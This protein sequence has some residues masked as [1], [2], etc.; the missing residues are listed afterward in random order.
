MK[1]H[2]LL[3]S[4]I[5]PNS[6]SGD[7][8]LV[9]NYNNNNTFLGKVYLLDFETTFTSPEVREEIYK[10]FSLFDGDYRKIINT[11]Y[12][13]FFLPIFA[14]VNNIKEILNYAPVDGI[15][16]YE[17]GNTP[18]FISEGAEGEG[19]R[20]GYR[21]NWMVNAYVYGA[22]NKQYK[23]EWVNKGGHGIKNW[24]LNKQYSLTLV[25][26]RLIKGVLVKNKPSFENT[27]PR[28]ISV[29]SLPLQKRNIESLT[30]FI[31]T[32][33]IQYLSYNPKLLN[34]NNVSYVNELSFVELSRVIFSSFRVKLP[35]TIELF[36]VSSRSLV[37]ELKYCKLKYD[38]YEKRLDKAVRLSCPSDETIVLSNTTAGF[39]MVSIHN[40]A[41]KQGLKHINMQYV[42]MG[43]ILYPEL[44]LA[45]TY[46][47]YSQKTYEFYKKYSSIYK[48]YL[49]LKN[50]KS[51]KISSEGIV[52]TIFTQ[53]DSYAQE[54]VDYL[55]V[56]LPVIKSRIRKIKII[57]KPHYRQKDLTSLYYFRDIYSF[58][59]VAEPDESVDKLLAIS[60]IAMTMHS[61]VIFEAMM[62][63]VPMIVYNPNDKYHDDVY[64]NDICFP[65]VNFVI[66]EPLESITILE[67]IDAYKINYEQRLGN[68][69][70][71]S[72]ATTDIKKILCI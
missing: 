68:F 55:N 45:D 26:N 4:S 64:N 38:I 22:F 23:C 7:I 59:R 9:S 13:K 52:F 36:N 32:D 18:F 40:V 58:V 3:D 66:N 29:V 50:N 17:G 1:L 65:E 24:W 33:S 67:N 31:K 5:T 42:A 27:T 44:E 34:S 14:I 60:T 20:K 49:P 43:K 21:T 16:L 71:S 15:V 30:S 54:Y 2:V 41:K 35:K 56:I 63:D 69:V 8:V 10:I 11:A 25:V 51:N 70:S 46:Y 39:D 6:S 57:I 48:L 12:V 53:P 72:E 61:S 62:N 19:A 37:K 47:L 28:I